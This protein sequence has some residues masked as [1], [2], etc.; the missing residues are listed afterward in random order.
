MAKV[1]TAYVEIKPDLTGFAEELETRL[2]AMDPAVRVDVKVDT[3]TAEASVRRVAS[4]MAGALEGEFRSLSDVTGKYTNDQIK[5]LE[6]TG[7][8]MAS[9]DKQRMKSFEAYADELTKAYEGQRKAESVRLKEFEIYADSLTRAENDRLKGFEKYADELTKRYEDQRKRDVAAAQQ[10]GKLAFQGDIDRQREI[11]EKV[12]AEEKAALLQHNRERD[13]INRHA[14]NKMVDDFINV[15]RARGGFI[16][17]ASLQ[18]AEIY[19]SRRF[20]DIG[21]SAG[22]RMST[23]INRHTRV[24][25]DEKNFRGFNRFLDKFSG[26]A[27]RSFSNLL[28]SFS[29]A[30]V[31]GGLVGVVGGIFAKSLDLVV[32]GVGMLVKVVQL[33]M[34]ATAKFGAEA[35]SELADS[36]LG[37]GSEVAKATAGM[38]GDAGRNVAKAGEGAA[39]AAGEMAA[40]AVATGGMSLLASAAVALAG[41]LVLVASGGALAVVALGVLQLALG[42]VLTI[43]IPLVAAVIALVSELVALG[44]ALVAS[45]GLIPGLVGA[46]LAAFAPLMLVFDKFQKM[47][48]NTA[49]HVGELYVVMER[50]K[51]AIWAVVSAGGL[52]AAIQGFVALAAPMKILST[53][54][55]AVAEAWNRFFLGF[56]KMA[57]QKDFLTGLVAVFGMG[58]RFVDMMA[59][60]VMRLSPSLLDMMVKS[61]PAVQMFLDSVKGLVFY[62][63]AWIDKVSASGELTT[64]LNSAA[65][66]MRDI[67]GVVTQLEPFVTGFVT[68]ILPAARSFTGIL[69]QMVGYWADWMNSTAGRTAILGFFDSMNAIIVALRPAVEAFFT[70]MVQFGPA[71]AAMAKPA[72]ESLGGLIRSLFDIGIRLAPA[73]TDFMN[74]FVAMMGDPATQASIMKVADALGEFIV[75]L[76]QVLTADSLPYM[77]QLFAIGIGFLADFTNWLTKLTI[78]VVAVAQ[79]FSIAHPHLVTFIQGMVDA[80]VV[81]GVLPSSLQQ[82]GI[83]AQNASKAGQDAMAAFANNGSWAAI[84]GHTREVAGYLDDLVARGL[85]ATDAVTQNIA[86]LLASTSE[87]DQL[88][89]EKRLAKIREKLKDVTGS[90]PG[91]NAGRDY[92]NGWNSNVPTA[93]GGAAATATKAGKVIAYNTRAGVL[94]SLTP[95]MTKVDWTTI[96]NGK[97]AFDTGKEIAGYLAKG[98]TSG[99]ANIDRVANLLNKSTGMNRTFTNII[100]KV[101]AYN[102]SL[103]ILGR[104]Q[105]GWQ[106]MLEQIQQFKQQ[107]FDTLTSKR[108]LVNYFGFIPTPQ[109]TVAQLSDQ[110]RVLKEFRTQL[111]ALLAAGVKPEIVA[112]WAAAG[113]DTA[114]NLAKGMQGATPEAIASLNSL[115]DQIGAEAKIV[116]QT[117]A[118]N[119]YG[120]GE[121]TVAGYIRAIQVNSAKLAAELQK[122]LVAAQAQAKATLAAHPIQL[123]PA[124]LKRIT[125][126]QGLGIGKATVD[127]FIKGLTSNSAA[128]RTAMQKI[129]DD[130]IAAA[131]KKL[132]IKSPSAVFAGIGTNTMVGYQ[133][134][135]IG[136]QRSVLNT[137]NGIYDKVIGTATP[138][139]GS[140]LRVGTGG[141]G[142]V[143]NTPVGPNLTA[144][145][146]LG[147]REITDIIDTRIDYS[148]STAARALLSGRRGG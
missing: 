59:D 126:A 16:D 83:N 17:D 3:K 148:E 57:S 118:D 8:A 38:V 134:G 143:G 142:Q 104:D 37:M 54:L 58:A 88:T 30:G 52:G 123:L 70:G 19:L 87:I 144:H 105:A 47:T 108:N 24:K 33:G 5:N 109:E 68:A 35:T 62:F 141:I 117:A 42:A 60:S 131:K 76:G 7:K 9:L 51:N 82:I 95:A 4:K 139:L 23:E 93:L 84:I 127:G 114:G 39:V 77:I 94:T 71:L 112:Q 34:E 119:M 124:D 72:S 13:I 90:R 15:V 99:K 31:F 12:W 66:L 36:L 113:P 122:M 29:G 43:I 73:V 49:E 116:S 98:L 27:T 80:G 20:G 138:T 63:A 61:A 111:D 106:D 64:F 53:G 1:A 133:Q 44:A 120:Y 103:K 40:T 32:K 140:R 102:A 14:A 147:T 110:L 128:A 78:A 50:L 21:V 115:Y 75:A 96:V 18:R 56:I 146:Y 22:R 74:R 145:V 26:D 97:K 89:G 125:Q 100:N 92:W 129:I 65:M 81:M 67:F 79:A 135:L 69:Q 10:Y 48:E 136:Q 6:K 137:V 28:R 41:G 101:K 45:L 91:T 121:A 132:G 2:A 86:Y 46:A 55:I 25:V 107:A 130:A 85:A 11:N